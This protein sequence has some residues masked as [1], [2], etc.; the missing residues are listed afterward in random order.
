MESDY[1]ENQC[2]L[3]EAKELVKQRSRNYA[4]RQFTF[5]RHQLPIIAK[6]SADEIYEEIING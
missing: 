6:N 2:T 4:K 5:F 1:L 3:E